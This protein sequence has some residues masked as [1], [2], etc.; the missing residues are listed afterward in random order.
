MSKAPIQSLTCYLFKEE[1]TTFENVFRIIDGNSL[2][3]KFNLVPTKESITFEIEGYIEK[4]KPNPPSWISKLSP[5]FDFD[6][7]IKNIS[8]SFVFFVK[9]ENR[10]LAF[11]M[12]YAHHAL[13]KTKIEYDFGLKVTLNEIN[14]KSIRGVDVRKLSATSHQKREVSTADGIMRDFEFDFNEEFLNS[15]SGKAFDSSF[16]NNLVGK[17]S[18]K[19]SVELKID[20]IFE[21]SKKLLEAYKKEN[22]KENFAFID[23]LKIIKD[24]TI[25]SAFKDDVR[26]SFI[27]NDKS[28][29]LFAY[30]NITD[31]DFHNY[32]IT[33]MQ[34]NKQY[35]DIN[36]DILF[37]FIAEK[38]IDF[39]TIELDKIGIILLN[40]ENKAINRYDIWDYLSYEFEIDDKKY[41]YSANQIFEIEPTYFDSIIKEIDAYESNLIDNAINIPSIL[42]WDEV[43][44]KTKKIKEVVENEGDYNLRF[45]SVN[46]DKCIC[47]DKKNFRN[48]PNRKN[49]QVEI[50]DVVTSSREYICVKTYKSSSSV[51]S[52]L[53][54]QGI[55]SAELL[56][57]CKDYRK[58]IQNSVKLKF[59]NFIDINNPQRNEITFVYAIAMK[60][61][62]RLSANLPFFS[63]ISLR[64]SIKNLTKMGF[65]VKL[66]RIPFEKK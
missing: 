17:E 20:Q 4:D 25:W 39:A 22:Y 9:V 16:A 28:K 5:L 52:H 1:V 23:N 60:K 62:G 15:L 41:I 65:N 29:I 11:T 10:I 38:K 14:Y 57:E 48:F 33:Y 59:K 26:N 37:N 8:N 27:N 58:K 30:P 47:L 24:D 34:Q 56:I 3:D 63:K 12:G 13:N 36:T 32:K 7:T 45:A 6:D 21:Y 43:N 54:M 61:D 2:K 50:S 49:D 55:V 51:L 35:A 46:T 18:L 53:F 64:Q 44:Q 42:Y 40:D 66:I 19:L 31:F